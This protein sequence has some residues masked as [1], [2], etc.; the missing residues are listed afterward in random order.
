VK[1]LAS[2]S[3]SAGSRARGP[4]LW[5]PPQIAAVAAPFTAPA[6]GT[7]DGRHGSMGGRH[8]GSPRRRR[9]TRSWKRT[10]RMRGWGCHA[11]APYPPRRWRQVRRRADDGRTCAVSRHCAVALRI[12]GGSHCAKPGSKTVLDLR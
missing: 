7:A 6:S 1:S 5:A 2:S 12:N 11:R 8:S 3:R 4:W 9:G 10:M